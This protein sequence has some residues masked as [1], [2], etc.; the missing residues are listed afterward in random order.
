MAPIKQGTPNQ[1]TPQVSICLVV[2]S[3][4]KEKRIKKRD[5]TWVD[6]LNR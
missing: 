6:K 4:K 2:V 3:T 1:I 5:D